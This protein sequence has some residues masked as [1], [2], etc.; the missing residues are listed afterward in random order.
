MKSTQ[1]KDIVWKFWETPLRKQDKKA[2]L[3]EGE[4]TL[5]RGVSRKQFLDSFKQEDEDFARG[6]EWRAVGDAHAEVGDIVITRLPNAPHE[7]AVGA[8]KQAVFNFVILNTPDPS[9]G[10][11]IV[12]TGATRCTG[13]T[14]SSESDGGFAPINSPMNTIAGEGEILLNYSTTYMLGFT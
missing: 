5:A 11:A 14:R 9:T 8:L 4:L 12:S 13:G 3:T 2:L 6:I 7:R 1:W 10:G